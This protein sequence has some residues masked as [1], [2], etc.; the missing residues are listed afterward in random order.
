MSLVI[1]FSMANN[2]LA[3]DCSS[4]TKQSVVLERVIRGNFHILLKNLK[5]LNRVS[6]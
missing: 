3:Y 1:L 6:G 4:F 2:T 5:G